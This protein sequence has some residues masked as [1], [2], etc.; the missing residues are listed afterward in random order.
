MAKAL[1]LCPPENFLLLLNDDIDVPWGGKTCTN[2]RG[3]ARF[4]RLCYFYICGILS[5]SWYFFRRWFRKWHIALWD[6]SYFSVLD[7]LFE[8]AATVPIDLNS[9]LFV[10]TLQGTRRC[11]PLPVIP[12]SR[13]LPFCFKMKELRYLFFFFDCRKPS[14]NAKDTRTH[15]ALFHGKLDGLG[16]KEPLLYSFKA[17]LFMGEKYNMG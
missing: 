4:G 14:L 17:L 8:I 15:S 11:F 16:M 3:T 9:P 10:E 5:P 1:C 6:D 7:S 13:V 12:D 2:S